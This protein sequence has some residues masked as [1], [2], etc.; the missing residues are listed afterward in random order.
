LHSK[1]TVSEI[2]FELNFSEPNHLM[3]FFKS[4]TGMTTTE[5]LSD[6]G[7]HFYS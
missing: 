2:A 6:N 1:L 4:Q 7:H 3:R 5:F